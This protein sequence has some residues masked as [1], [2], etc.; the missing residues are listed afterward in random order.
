MTPEEKIRIKARFESI[1]AQLK[2]LANDL[3]EIEVELL[4]VS[5]EPARSQRPEDF[6]ALAE[7]LRCALRFWYRGAKDEEPRLRYVAPF[8]LVTADGEEWES[9]GDP[10]VGFLAEDF[11]DGG[12][13]KRFNLNRLSTEGLALDRKPIPEA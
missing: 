6:V 13:T 1:Y 11:D 8:R 10:F 2:K 12:R 4:A 3:D 7:H 9:S 5:G